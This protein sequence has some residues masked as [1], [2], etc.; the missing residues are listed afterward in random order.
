M[1]PDVIKVVELKATK[2]HHPPSLLPR[3]AAWLARQQ[4]WL[5]SGA[6]QTLNSKHLHWRVWS[7]WT[8][9]RTLILTGTKRD[10]HGTLFINH[11][12]LAAGGCQGLGGKYPLGRLL[13]V[14]NSTTRLLPRWLLPTL[15]NAI[16]WASEPSST[17]R[18][19]NSI[20]ADKVMKSPAFLVDCRA[21]N[22]LLFG[23]G[24]QRE[25]AGFYNIEDC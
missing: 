21:F 8:W 22:E 9:L 7:Q 2:T 5:K 13:A 1:H 20:L 3:E 4:R 24:Y 18:T 6:S 25:G 14:P 23:V 17:A 11:R 15:R 12:R 16:S 19:L 10:Q